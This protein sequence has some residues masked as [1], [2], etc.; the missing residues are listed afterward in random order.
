MSAP[1]DLR[2]DCQSGRNCFNVKQR[3]KF[4]VFDGCFPGIIGFTD[5]DAVVEICGHQLWL[6]WKS[7]GP[8]PLGQMKLFWSQISGK[9]HHKVFVVWGDAEDMSV[10]D[11]M[12][13]DNLTAPAKVACDFAQLY[14]MVK[15]WARRAQD[16]S[17][18]ERI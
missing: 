1:T 6:E 7:G 3:L 15:E 5:L 17:W 4:K 18:M 8:V 13:I 9:P 12:V 10:T 16:A 2:Y 14:E 11:V